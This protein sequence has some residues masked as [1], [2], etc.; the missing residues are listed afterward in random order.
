MSKFPEHQRAARSQLRI[1]WCLHASN[2]YQDAINYL[3]AAQSKFDKQQQLPEA[4][5]L[6]GRS[7]LKLNQQAEAVTALD[8]AIA[9]NGNWENIDQVLLTK[10]ECQ[11][12]LNQNDPAAETL[13]RL[14]STL[15]NSNL[16][17]QALYWLGEL[18]Q[19]NDKLDEASNWFKEVAEKYQET[20]FAG[21]ATH[22]MAALFFAKADYPQSRAWA[23]RLIDGKASD[24]LKQRG[25]YL[26]G[27]AYHREMDYA[28]ATADLDLYRG[29]PVDED[30][31][32]DATYV[33]ALCNIHVKKFDPA[34]QLLAELLSKQPD[35]PNADQAYYELGHALREQA[36]KGAEAA[37]A[38]QWIV[39]NRPA[40]KLAAESWFR[41]AQ[42]HVDVASTAAGEAKNKEFAAAEEALS[43]GLE[44]ATEPGLRE[45]MQ[46][47][48]GDLQFRQQRYEDAARTLTEQVSKFGTGK[49][50]G[51]ATFLAAQARY[52]LKQFDQALPLF[53][54][55]ADVPFPATQ[56]EQIEAYR[57]QAAYRAGDC[58][59]KL[60]QWPE[61]QRHFQQ[62]IDQFPKFAAQRSTIR[63]GIR[64]ATTKPT[65][66]RRQSLR[67]S[68]DGDRNRNGRQSPLHDWRNRIWP[69]AVRERDRAV[70]DCDRWVSLRGLAGV[71]PVRDGSLLSR[72]R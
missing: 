15:P 37:V 13:R 55:I 14:A 43:S 39:S 21:P 59:A 54:K 72:T 26:R 1:G 9:A 56:A 25:R 36:D 28:K 29:N 49:Y 60:N 64:P 7:H 40:S 41:V 71:G 12:A 53:I 34:R 11:R 62:L 63:R 32:V 8:Q 61:S 5:L 38:F 18:A 2:K 27:I 45:N 50:A 70:F 44:K 6:I 16:R 33:N 20:E 51:P 47:L 30:E 57:S 42:H 67:T 10:A 52:E 24:E 65:R 23:S 46:Y 58:A 4:L 48:L 22:A 35:F 31:L 66:Q 17:A 68:D 19:Q 69:E 3:R